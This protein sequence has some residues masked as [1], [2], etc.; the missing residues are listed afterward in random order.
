MSSRPR[1]SILD[2]LLAATLAVAVIGGLAGIDAEI[3][4]LSLRS[5]SALRVLLLWA[6]L[7]AIRLRMGVGAVSEW[8]F[9]MAMQT[10]I[11]LSVAA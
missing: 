11:A 1:N 7:L 9:R 4:G 10:V 5:H 2:W 3:D 6:V 8:L